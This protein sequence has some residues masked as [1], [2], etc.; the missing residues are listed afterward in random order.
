[1]EKFKYLVEARILEDVKYD[2]NRAFGFG[3]HCPVGTMMHNSMPYVIIL[4]FGTYD[5]ELRFRNICDE[6]FNEAMVLR[7]D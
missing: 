4:A 5:A 7:L 3:N 6:L 2:M 1:M